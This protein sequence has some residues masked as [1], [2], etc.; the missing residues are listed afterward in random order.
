ME[1][2]PRPSDGSRSPEY[3][4]VVLAALLHDVGLFLQRIESAAQPP[5]PHAELSGSFIEQHRAAFADPALVRALVELHHTTPPSDTLAT[6]ADAQ[7]R[8]H[9]FVALIR[10]ADHLSLRERDDHHAGQPP[11]H[12]RSLFQAIRI[13][14]PGEE[15]YATSGDTYRYPLTSYLD[16]EMAPVKNAPLPTAS[17]YAQFA[18][19]FQTE[20]ST[21]FSAP[22]PGMT[23]TLLHLVRKYLWCFPSDT[24]DA[25]CDISLADHMQTTAA[26]AACLYRYHEEIGWTE[27]HAHEPEACRLL[28]V[29]GDLSGIQDYLYGITSIGSGGVAKR[30]R[31]HSFKISVLTDL[32]CWHLLRRLHLPMACQIISAGGQFYLTVP[33]TPQTLETLAQCQQEI[34]QA[35]LERF[36]GALTLSIAHEEITPALLRAEQFPRIFDAVKRGL[37]QAKRQKFREVLSAGTHT[38]HLHFHGAG[39]CP[40]CQKY[41][42]TL[43][44]DG[45]TA[46][47]K[48]CQQDARIGGMLPRTRYLA[49]SQDGSGEMTLLGYG[50]RLLERI[51]PTSDALFTWNIRPISTA[52]AST[53]TYQMVPQHP[54]GFFPYA[55]YVPV[56]T[57]QAACDAYNQTFPA[58]HADEGRREPE[59]RARV[60]EIKSFTALAKSRETGA[61]R[62]GVL[63][64]D[65]DHLGLIFSLGLEQQG[66]LSR[67]TTLSHLLQ[68]FFCGSVPRLI[69]AKYP[70]QYVGYAG[71]DDVMVVGPW[72]QTIRFAHH[73]QEAFRTFTACNP[74][75]SLS[76][77][78][79]VY[80]AHTPIAIMAPQ[81]G[82]LLDEA[83]HQGRNRLAVF[84]T[85][86]PWQEYPDVADWTALLIADIQERGNPM[87]PSFLYRLLGYQRQALAWYASQG[88]D[89]RSL[90]YRPH[91]AYDLGRN[92]M[93]DSGK[94][95]ITPKL[96]QRLCQLL[97]PDSEREWQI[98]SAPIAWAALAIRKGGA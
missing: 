83:K 93:A 86:I 77:G 54:S 26:L 96:H 33:N 42:A 12:L 22:Y 84:N 19:A 97:K 10:D 56:W 39:A 7:A 58:N 60:G 34:A 43:A 4:S 57:E 72:D 71:G 76:A 20:F 35:L 80:G 24:A 40:V 48:E 44:T 81:S 82:E 11:T 6:Q 14:N 21:L 37:D 30:L 28:L 62:L 23:D 5:T 89:V 15:E 65:V 1:N 51:P 2:T 61:V 85:V 9:H 92:F 69:S 49:I 31:G 18:D 87:S 74:A 32:C 53:P 3:E 59:D 13:G 66:S 47:C 70:N 8:M 36:H 41:P 98:L 78:I 79:G 67:L 90:L 29:G 52:T 73:L 68:A 38:L 27:P 64:A 45:E 17:E 16:G 50:V 94:L 55:G 46:P 91:L 88:A 75:F 25:V 95:R 63:R